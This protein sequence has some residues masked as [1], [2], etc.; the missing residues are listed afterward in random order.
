MIVSIPCYS[1]VEIMV[2]GAKVKEDEMVHLA[3]YVY[4]NIYE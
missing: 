4:L 3:L 2:E 1:Q